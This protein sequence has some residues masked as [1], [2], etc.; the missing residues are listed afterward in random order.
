MAERMRAREL[1]KPQPSLGWPDLRANALIVSLALAAIA[2]S[3]AVAPDSRGVFAAGLALIAI[4]IAVV[5]A[6]HLLIPDELNALGFGLG[7]AYA[8]S[9]NH[10]AV[11]AITLAALRGAALA[12]VFLA[13]RATYQWLRGRQGI[14]LGDIK[15]AAVGGAWLDWQ[16]MPIAI[17]IAA[18][19][20]LATYTARQLVLGRSMRATGRLPFGLF[21]APAIW[22]GWVLDQWLITAYP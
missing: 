20:A 6:R 1:R 10:P 2:A 13:V 22:I 7:L 15:L 8:G 5:D 18:L 3:L 12:L 19:A 9:T 11:E 4:V 14:G 17:N 21:L 16:M